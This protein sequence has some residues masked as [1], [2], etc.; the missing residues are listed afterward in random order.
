MPLAKAY[1]AAPDRSALIQGGDSPLL[2]HGLL[3]V[4][5]GPTAGLLFLVGGSPCP[6]GGPATSNPA[7]L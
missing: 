4:P 7:A 3:T 1:K 6:N 2:G 5:L